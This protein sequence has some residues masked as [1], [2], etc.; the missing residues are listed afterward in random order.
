MVLLVAFP[1]LAATSQTVDRYTP[2]DVAMPWTLRYAFVYATDPDENR[3]GFV[4]PGGIITLTSGAL[5]GTAPIT[6]YNNSGG[7]VTVSSTGIAGDSL[8]S[9]TSAIGLDGNNSF[10]LN[11]AGTGDISGITGITGGTDLVITAYGRNASIQA[12]STDAIAQGMK[13]N[14]NLSIL[15]GLNGTIDVQ[16]A[17]GEWQDAVYAYGDITITGGLNGT[18]RSL[19]TPG[20]PLS[21]A[22]GVASATGS[23]AISGGLGGSVQAT[24]QSGDAAALWATQDISI[25]GGLSGVLQASGDNA[26][27]VN[28]IRDLAISGGLSGTV[29]GTAGAGGLAQGLYAGRNLA[30]A[31]GLSGTV[32][33]TAGANGAAQGL[34]AG[35]KETGT[36]NGG[37]AAIPLAISGTVAATAGGLAVAVSST[38]AMNLYVTGTLSGVDTSGGGDGYAI[39]AG[40]LQSS[41]APWSWAEGNADNTVTLGSGAR[42][43]G[44]VDLGNGTSTLN[45]LGTGTAGNQFLAGTSGTINLVAGDGAT[46][47]FWSLVPSAVNASTFGSVTINPN[48]A[49]TFNENVT[50][51]GNITD[52]GALTYDLGADKTYSGV[53]SGSGSFT[54]TGSGT[55]TLAGGNT[56]G[57]ATTVSAGTLRAGAANTFSPNSAVTVDAAGTLDLNSLDQSIAGLSGSGNVSLGAAALSVNT[58]AGTAYTFS[59]AISGTGTLKKFGA[60]ALALTGANTYSG[61]TLLAGGTLTV[62]GDGNLGASP[63]PLI[64]D[65]G[66]L[67]AA[68]DLAT[69]RPITVVTS[70]GIDNGGNAL[71]LSGTL[72]GSGNL[73][74]SGSGTDTL[75]A[76]FDGSTYAGTATLAAGAM[77]LVPG[78]ILGGTL[79]LEPGTTLFGVGTV[80][81]LNV[82]GTV[83]PGNSPG[84]ITVGGDYVQTA[85]GNYICQIT[86]TANDLIAVAGNATLAGSLTIQP[87][88]AYYNSGSAWT[89]LT[90]AGG[91]AGAYP[92]VTSDAKPLNWILAPVYTSNSVVV[93][94]QRQS[95]SASAQNSRASA[96]GSSL[97]AVA[98]NATGEMA[99][100]LKTLD[101]SSTIGGYQTFGTLANASLGVLSAEPYD[102]F[103]HVLFDGGRLLTAVQRAGLSG[104]PSDG[105]AAF[106]SPTDIGPGNLA[107]MAGPADTPLGTGED[108]RP[109]GENRL[110]I[111]LKPLGMLSRQ[112]G[113]ADRTGYD[114]VTGG[115]TGAMLYSPNQTWTFAL[116]PGFVSQSVAMH[117]ESGGKGVIEDWSLALLG[118]YRNGGWHADAAV[119]A[120]Y[121]AYRA[122]R[123]LALPT[124]IGQ[125]KAAWN[126]WN[127]SLSGGGGYDF[128]RGAWIAGPFAAA[129]WQ[130]V[131]QDGFRESRV[132]T[133]GQSLR[134]CDA[135]TLN[136][137]LGGRVARRFETASGAVF[138]PEVR[139]AWDAQW[140]S[141]PRYSTS[142]FI[143][144][145]GSGYHPATADQHYHSLL[146]DAGV[147]VRLKDRLSFSARAGM[148]LFRLGHE[149]RTASVGLGYSF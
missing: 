51:A 108:R 146:L 17:A 11:I 74:L 15:N 41:R 99:T 47:T 49:L 92:G 19:L 73:T 93:T 68:A 104:E 106:S 65:G 66:T 116:A 32:A 45:L 77:Q 79:S 101:F 12:T 149:A 43:V 139:A 25:S 117:T 4:S 24:A 121:D 75:A 6:L 130:H 137:T 71:T 48:A 22:N 114:T 29:S 110:G 135:D 58:A 122:T 44:K 64:F 69:A 5:L 144:A 60:G 37:G 128:R 86:P 53:I 56:Y 87:E 62:V 95:Y 142:S 112:Q 82:G 100:L 136:T 145:P 133:L 113:D 131:R 3:I 119:R 9:T 141:T 109:A 2:D 40:N 148:E 94:L 89:V 39:R 8:L 42:L 83:S 115:I 35:Y 85:T 72:T 134:A 132:G 50:I 46:A 127:T 36:L 61:G 125:T 84:T 129:Q 97:D 102:T 28:A 138:T 90:A 10:F 63:G 80:R 14:G 70:G 59:G 33:V 67:Q 78:S 38:G 124:F 98:Y 55:L 57:G 105:S 76:S 23:I 13:S 16:G 52:N 34:T 21:F 1:V 107:A 118:G 18:L 26:Y 123:N 103:T 7:N 96:V 54:K 31:D 88:F 91:V 30:I 140:L 143:G 126:G 111:F 20:S 27:T 120:G 81:N 147:T